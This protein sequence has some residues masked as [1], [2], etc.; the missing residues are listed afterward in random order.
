M[1]G[2]LWLLG[3]TNSK[4]SGHMTETCE[5]NVFQVPKIFF[6]DNEDK[7]AFKNYL[8][9]SLSLS[10]SDGIISSSYITLTAYSCACRI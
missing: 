9:L 3:W 6:S 2:L 4:P 1:V 7:L 10:L 8:S 5:C